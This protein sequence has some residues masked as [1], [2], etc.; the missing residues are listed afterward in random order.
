MREK[1][2]FELRILGLAASAVVL[3]FV[4][5]GRGQA[6]V[7]TI[8]QLP[9]NFSI[10]TAQPISPL[11]FPPGYQMT[12]VLG[13][14]TADSVDP[15]NLG[16]YAIN[17]NSGDSLH[18]AVTSIPPVRPTELFL[19]EVSQN[20]VAIAAG[21]AS[22]GLGSVIDF[23]IPI[24]ETGIWDAQVVLSPSDQNTTPYFYDL[25]VQGAT[26]LGP[27]NPLQSVPEP[28]ALVMSSILLGMFGVAWSYRRWKQS[29]LVA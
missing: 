15:T 7:I 9:P 24:G 23:T 8:H 17:V 21:N 16:F 22:D 27:V 29:P 26:G 4:A 19:Y 2:Q 11:F 13:N 6:S 14:G 10:S 1:R 5:V 18:L 12:D 28:S 25:T 3:L 20:L